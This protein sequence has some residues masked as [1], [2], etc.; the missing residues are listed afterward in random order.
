MTSMN[1]QTQLTIRR[2]VEDD[3]RMVRAV[4][5]EMLRDTPLA[6]CETVEE[7]EAADEEQWRFRARRGQ[8]GPTNIQLAAETGTG[9][10]AGFLACFVESP[11][12]GH[13]VSVFVA[14][15]WRGTG[16][17]TQMFE[18]VRR[19][20][21]DEAGLQRLRLLVHEDNPRARAFYRREGFTETGATEPYPL[22]PAQREIEMAT[23]LT[24]KVVDSAH[25]AL[26][27]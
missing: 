3:W 25:A 10:W 12:Q 21:R 9:S 16:L 23:T 22:D 5:L 7:A 27:R 8:S 13:V 19:W 11:G 2:V 20:A 18:A 24:G 15:A 14:P 26:E 17:A 1:D 4:R 6:Y